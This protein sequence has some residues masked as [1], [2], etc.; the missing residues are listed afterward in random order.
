MYR[1][2][3]NHD[4]IQK[5]ISKELAAGFRYAFGI[6]NNSYE[7][8]E[9][10]LTLFCRCYDVLSSA[11]YNEEL[12]SALKCKLETMLREIEDTEN[13]YTFD[14][15]GEY[16]LYA[17]MQAFSIRQQNLE[18]FE[19]RRP[20]LD[21]S[22]PCSVTDQEKSQVY[23]IFVDYFKKTNDDEM[24][25]EDI[26]YKAKTLTDRVTYFPKMADEPNDEAPMFDILFWDRD[27]LLYEDFGNIEMVTKIIR[28]NADA[29][30][31]IEGGETEPISGSFKHP[32]HEAAE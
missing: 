17:I 7:V 26:R 13:E 18:Y 2:A 15:F 9:E 5:I 20:D 1:L 4:F 30:G 25:D 32:L 10:G 8:D 14:C 3:F 21:F 23:S 19:A 16:L 29:L 31:C 27:F 11:E 28:Q 6:D 24:T 22:W 12:F